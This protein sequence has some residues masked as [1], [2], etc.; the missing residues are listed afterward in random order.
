MP[1]LNDVAQGA[2]AEA[3]HVQQ[4][5]DLLKGTGNTPVALTGI[6]DAASYALAV[7]N[8]G[9]GGKAVAFYNADG[10]VA[11]E[12]SSGKATLAGPTLTGTV[13][14]PAGGIPTAALAAGAASQVVRSES[15]AVTATTST[16]P[17]AIG[18]GIAAMTLL[19]GSTVVVDVSVA[20]SNNTAGQV[21][22]FYVRRDTDAWQ[23]PYAKV[24]QQAANEVFEI[25][26]RQVFTGHMAGAHSFE[27]GWAVSAGTV[28]TD[29]QTYRAIT[30]TE[31]RR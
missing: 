7:K 24:T 6:N 20:A 19:L 3:A 10:S 5:I 13:T 28:T 21:M 11:F 9:T 8:S 30:A 12:V 26:F 4:L 15:A 31:H 22:F 2:L 17:V 14:Y 16:S 25:A 27:I 1:S 23:G 18:A 29:A